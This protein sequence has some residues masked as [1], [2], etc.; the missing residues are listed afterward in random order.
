MSEKEDMPPF[1]GTWNN[2]YL[3]ILG[4]LLLTI[5]AFHLFTQYFK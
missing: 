4:W 2:V 5:M 1:L 3:F